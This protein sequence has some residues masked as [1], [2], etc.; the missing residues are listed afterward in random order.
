MKNIA[1]DNLLE[2]KQLLLELPEELYCRSCSELSGGTIGQ[3][4][5]HILEFYVCLSEGYHKGMVNYDNRNRDL[6]LETSPKIAAERIDKLCDFI[7]QI[8]LDRELKLEGNWNVQSD[9]STIVPSNYRRELAYNIEHSIHHQALIR[10]GLIIFG[11]NELVNSNFGIA[12]A[13]I[14]YR[15]N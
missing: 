7:L 15:S 10:V 13:T 1:T 8:D 4:I 12:P 9:V 11:G 6:T 14:R 5:R 3:H 2:L